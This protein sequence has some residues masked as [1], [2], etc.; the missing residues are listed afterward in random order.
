MRRVVPALPRGAGDACMPRRSSETRA[1]GGRRMPGLEVR[2]FD[3]P[4]E[5]RTPEKT[6]VEVVRMAGATAGRFTF[7]PGWRGAESVRPVAGGA[8]W[9][10][11]HVGGGHQGRPDAPHGGGP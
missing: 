7:Q 5:T 2:G 4:D 8:S 10:M 6:R 11:R 1:E 3:A 9:Q